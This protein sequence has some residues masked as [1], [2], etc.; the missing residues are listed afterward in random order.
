LLDPRKVIPA[1]DSV[2]NLFGRLNNWEEER[3]EDTACNN[4]SETGNLGEMDPRSKF[5][6]QAEKRADERKNNEK[7]NQIIHAPETL[8][9]RCW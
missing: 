6:E 2:Q 9:I 5:F 3:Q 4:G 1:S 7:D 8:E